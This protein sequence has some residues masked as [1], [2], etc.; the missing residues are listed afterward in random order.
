MALRRAHRPAPTVW[1]GNALKR[2]A[3][4]TAMPDR[5]LA[6]WPGGAPIEQ[7]TGQRPATAALPDQIATWGMISTFG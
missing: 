2:D 7:A 1:R 6:R 5:R 3:K 4:E